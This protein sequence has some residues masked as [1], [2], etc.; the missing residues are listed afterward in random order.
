MADLLIDANAQATA[1]RA[2]CEGQPQDAGLAGV[3]CWYRGTVA[4]GFTDNTGKT[5]PTSPRTASPWPA[6]SATTRT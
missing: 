2:A 5:S 4:K 6:G 1:A 3:R